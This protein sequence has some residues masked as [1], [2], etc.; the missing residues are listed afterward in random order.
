MAKDTT[1]TK[2]SSNG[3]PTTNPEIE[4]LISG[5]DD[6]SEPDI[7]GWFKPVEGAEFAGNAVKVIQIDDDDDTP[8]DVLLVKLKAPCSFAVMEESPITVPVGEI[9]AVGMRFGLQELLSYVEKKALV[10]AKATGKQ[11]LKQGRTKW[12]WVIRA[13]TKKRTAPVA[14]VARVA[15]ADADGGF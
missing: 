9:L 4:A 15:G 8:R 6:V 7:A 13:D 5:L 11:K 10:Y 3:A 12:N 14:P 1:S 2:S